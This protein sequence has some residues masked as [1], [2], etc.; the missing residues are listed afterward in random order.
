MC[1]EKRLLYS[2][3]WCTKALTFATWT[4]LYLYNNWFLYRKQCKR[5]M[6]H[7]PLWLA[8]SAWS[9]WGLSQGWLHCHVHGFTCWKKTK[10]K[11]TPRI[12]QVSS[13]TSAVQ[14]TENLNQVQVGMRPSVQFTKFG[15]WRAFLLSTWGA[16]NYRH[17]VSS[18]RLLGMFLFKAV[19]QQQV[20]VIEATGPTVCKS[21]GQTPE[22]PLMPTVISPDAQSDH[23]FLRSWS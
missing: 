4:S 3:G 20:E 21:L 9:H 22:N 1:W 19:G 8:S 18:T 17:V 12:L 10:N 2:H 11:N 7:Y 13:I 6:A 15:S 23:S 16:G 5:W 14:R